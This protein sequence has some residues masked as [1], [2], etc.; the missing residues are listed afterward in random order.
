M[1][2]IETYKLHLHVFIYYYYGYDWLESSNENL[3]HS[4]MLAYY[5]RSA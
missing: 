3:L 5:V 1:L 4:E 2:E